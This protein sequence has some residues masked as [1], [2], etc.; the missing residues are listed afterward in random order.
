MRQLSVLLALAL[1]LIVEAIVA[2]GF[3]SPGNLRDML[4]SNLPVL[5]VSIGMTMVILI[6]EIDISV[7]AQ[8]AVYT[9]LAGVLA[10]TGLPMPL[11]TIAVGLSGWL[12]GAAIGALV[13]G[14]K[15][16]SIVV[17][18]AAMV[19]LRD[20]LRWATGGAFVQNLPSNFQWFGMSQVAGETFLCATAAMM[21]AICA[22][23]LRNVAAGRGIYAVGS[24]AEAARLAGLPVRT[25]Q[26]GCFAA[27]G[28]FTAAA[29]L[30]NSIRFSELQSGA[31][32]GLELKAIAAV[33][34]GG[35]S[36]RGGRGT[37]LG[38]LAGVL[39]LGVVGP[40]LTFAGVNAYWEKAIQG[41]IILAAVAADR[42]TIRWER[43]A[44]A[45]R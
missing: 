31:G 45:A 5:V 35:T 26:V 30:L 42:F 18:L 38:T 23:G 3:F 33:V 25:I 19:V 13:A 14:W 15:L 21:F 7:A 32:T 6:G 22:W 34:V 17:T 2:P 10:K 16:P 43:H 12:I 44:A 29:A 1:L 40:A 27:L 37:L 9:V 11:V 8:F 20:A 4:L 39:L 41:A 28:A 24:E 36:V